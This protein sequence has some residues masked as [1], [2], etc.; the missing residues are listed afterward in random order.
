MRAQKA[1][2]LLKFSTMFVDFRFSRS[3][4]TEAH[5]K[6][7]NVGQRLPVGLMMTIKAMYAL[8]CW[9]LLLRGMNEDANNTRSFG[10]V[11]LSVSTLLQSLSLALIEGNN[12]LG[13]RIVKKP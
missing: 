11:H 5:S 13:Y 2:F 1:Y 4:G 12:F 6:S 3:R 10:A 7:A 8:I 9:F